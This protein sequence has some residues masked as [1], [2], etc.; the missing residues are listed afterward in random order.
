MKIRPKHARKKKQRV[1]NQAKT[2]DEEGAKEPQSDGL[3]TDVPPSTGLDTD[4]DKASNPL[5]ACRNNMS[6]NSK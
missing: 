1:E 4:D 5:A 3:D 2:T 6:S